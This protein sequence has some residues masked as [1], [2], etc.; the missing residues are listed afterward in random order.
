MTMLYKVKRLFV[1]D[2]KDTLSK[3]N[4]DLP[5]DTTQDKIKFGDDFRIRV[6][7]NN[8]AVRYMEMIYKA[9]D[10]IIYIDEV[11]AVIPPRKN[12]PQVFL[13]VW[14]RGRERNIGGWAST[15]RPVSIPILFLTEAY[16]F[17]VFRLNNEN[18]RKTVSE[19]TDK[20]IL[21]KVPDQYGFYYFDV[22]NDKL[23]YTRK[24]PI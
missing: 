3:W 23:R 22:I 19:Y 13:D 10:A 11:N 18:D 21:T 12:P 4:L 5:D 16:H 17:F 7:D 8:E 15:Q 2:S 24:L 14:Q 20:A 6:T 1:I 9:G